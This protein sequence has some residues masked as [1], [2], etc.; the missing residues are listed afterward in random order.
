MVTARASA[1]M[2][3][4]ARDWRAAHAR[5][6]SPILA[7]TRSAS[8]PPLPGRISTVHMQQILPGSGMQRLAAGAVQVLRRAQERGPAAAHRVFTTGR[9]PTW[10][11]VRDWRRKVT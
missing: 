7:A 10:G 2:T 5:T 9:T 8:C 1:L 6:E 4:T 3:A 11:P